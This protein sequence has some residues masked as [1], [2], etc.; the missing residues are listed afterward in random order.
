MCLELA[1]RCQPDV[2]LVDI[3][4]PGPNGWEVARRLR[5]SGFDQLVGRRI[6]NCGTTMCLRSR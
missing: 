4:M 3:A 6:P 1:A 5:G 2:L